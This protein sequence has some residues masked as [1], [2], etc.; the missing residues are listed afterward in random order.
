MISPLISLRVG[1]S[2]IAFCV[3]LN[4]QQQ[5][6]DNRPFFSV[7]DRAIVCACGGGCLVLL[8]SLTVSVCSETKTRLTKRSL[9]SILFA[10]STHSPVVPGCMYCI[11]AVVHTYNKHMNLGLS[12]STPAYMCT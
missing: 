3:F 11:L 4:H 7:A 9:S 12:L 6:Q 2:D 1:G 5:Q 8:I 10:R